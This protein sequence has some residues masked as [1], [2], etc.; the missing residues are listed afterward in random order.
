MLPY[1][2][3]TAGEVLMAYYSL[4]VLFIALGLVFL[5]VPM[6]QLKTVFRRMRSSVT[7][8]IGGAVLLVAGIVSIILGLRQ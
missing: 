1:Q 8:R 5:L 7:T 6:E 3:E 4:G 2:N